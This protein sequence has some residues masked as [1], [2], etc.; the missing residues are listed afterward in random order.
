LVGHW[1]L[2]ETGIAVID[3]EL[4]ASTNET[5]RGF[6]PMLKEIIQDQM[7]RFTETEVTQF[8]K[9]T[10]GT[11]KYATTKTGPHTLDLVMVRE[12][13]KGPK[14]MTAKAAFKDGLLH[15][16]M[17]GTPY[18][19]PLRR[20]TQAD[21]D[22]HLAAVEAAKVATKNGP[23]PDAEPLL[24]I[25]WLLRADPA[26]VQR[27]LAEEPD[28]IQIRDHSAQT[29]LHHAAGANKLELV[30]LLLQK[31]ADPIASDSRKCSP[32]IL[33]ISSDKGDQI[34]V[35][36]ALLAAGADPNQC[37]AWGKAP[38]A[39]ALE[40]DPSGSRAVPVL[41]KKHGA[42]LPQGALAET[43][44]R[45]IKEDDVASLE[46]LLGSGAIGISDPI[47]RAG[48]T[49]LHA[50][51]AS[52]NTNICR[53]LIKLGASVNAGRPVNSAVS[54]GNIEMV[55]LLLDAGAETNAGKEP[56]D[57]A[58]YMAAAAGHVEITKLLLNC[59]AD[60]N[61]KDFRGVTALAQ[62]VLDGKI[63]VV[64]TLV[65]AGAD[66]KMASEKA[67]ALDR[68]DMLEIL[69]RQQGPERDK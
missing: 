14:Q 46:K 52:G 1:V 13:P 2:D 5:L 21:V 38:L 11:G 6:A 68:K 31:G 40:R 4:A 22:R 67:Q 42:V 25:D 8:M 66:T 60:V 26:D 17:P 50:A 28:L 56:G 36:K 62:A 15:L 18:P 9:G 55:K 48:N 51:V 39:F 35:V 34:D 58:I 53:R 54:S 43:L 32:L 19:M 64:R 45:W 65:A 20:A 47:D 59:G 7:F 12:T 37:D 61:S 27:K 30:Q 41:L 57:P 23:K 63:E 69:G 16:Q 24:R 10:S 49:L 29:A 44:H 3:K 33:A